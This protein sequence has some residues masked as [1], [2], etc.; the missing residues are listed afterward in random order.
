MNGTN[1]N[2]FYP[3]FPFV[4]KNHIEIVNA[5]NYLKLQNKDISRIKVFFTFLKEDDMN[6]YDKISQYKL[7]DNFV[8]LGKLDSL[9]MDYM[10]RNVDLVVFPSY[11]ETFGLPLIEASS[12]G[13]PILCAEREYSKE[14]IEEYDGVTFIK[15]NSPRLWATN[16]F[17]EYEEKNVYKEFEYKNDNSWSYFFKIINQTIKEK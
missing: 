16:I 4:Y 6:I 12:Y 3:A 17:R 7:K 15:I 1:Y 9:E 14:V 13:V 11:I 5:L 2:I 10:Y 8:F